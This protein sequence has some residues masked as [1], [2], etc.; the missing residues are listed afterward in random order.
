M[1]R[2]SK[3]ASQLP[4]RTDNE[5]KNV[6]NTHLKKR[7]SCR[8]V[9]KDQ[10]SKESSSISSPSSSSSS[11]IISSGKR[12]ADTEFDEHQCDQNKYVPKKPRE[13]HGS[14]TV[15]EKLVQQSSETEESNQINTSKGVVMTTKELLDSS[16]SSD[17]SV[18]SNSSQVDATRPKDQ[19]GT[20]QFGFSEPYDV[21][22]GLNNLEE[23]NKPEIISISDTGLEIP[24]ECD[25]DFWSMLDN[26]GPFQSHEVEASQSTSF[27]EA[28]DNSREVDSRTWFQYL[29]NE[30]GLEATTEDEIQNSAKVAAA[31]TAD[32][33]P[34]ETY[35]TL[36]K[37]E[38]DPG[39]TFFQLWN[40]SLQSSACE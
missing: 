5:I 13:G 31:A 19:M 15:S 12:R 34:Q 3:I 16:C 9:K 24:L 22:I 14:M 18:V 4:G 7:L 36:L 26:L 21:A 8:D 39:V 1:L 27:G 38:V 10:E 32:P 2:W 23:V 11:T 33:M 28:S 35:E 25:F 29:E 37:P 17:N 6:W 40:A 30:L 20:S